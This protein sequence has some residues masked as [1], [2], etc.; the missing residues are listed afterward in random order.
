MDEDIDKELDELPSY[1][2]CILRFFEKLVNKI[3]KSLKKRKEIEKNHFENIKNGV[4]N[5]IPEINTSLEKFNEWD[6]LLYL[7]EIPIE[8]ERF[9]ISKTIK[10]GC[11]DFNFWIFLL[12][13]SF[14]RNSSLYNFFKINI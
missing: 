6:E 9:R 5:Y 12:F 10:I 11:K 14:N 7:K 13:N 1:L 3:V 2:K 4:K 8:T